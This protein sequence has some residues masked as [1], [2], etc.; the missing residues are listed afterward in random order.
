MSSHG[1]VDHPGAAPGG[2]RAAALHYDRKVRVRDGDI[3]HG[4]RPQVTEGGGRMS[5]RRSVGGSVSTGQF[6]DWIQHNISDFKQEEVI[7]DQ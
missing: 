5:H 6:T 4:T 3:R 2:G 1:G 7:I